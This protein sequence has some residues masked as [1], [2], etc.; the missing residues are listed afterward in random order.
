MNLNKMECYFCG[1]TGIIGKFAHKKSLCRFCFALRASYR[2]AKKHGGEPCCSTTRELK[3]KFT[4]ICHI[5][6]INESSLNKRLCMDHDHKTGKFRGWLCS[7]CNTM[8]GMACD[9]M[10]TLD[11]A[12]EYL[13]KGL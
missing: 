9:S 7:K 12:M 4:G 8:L 2:D 3:K 10:D 13:R 11:K 1:Y 5:C 6:G